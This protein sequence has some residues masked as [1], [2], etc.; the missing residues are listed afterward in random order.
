MQ[1][2]GKTITTIALVVSNPAEP[3][4]RWQRPSGAAASGGALPAAGT[5]IVAPTSLLTQWEAEFHAKARRRSISRLRQP[6]PPPLAS[7]MT[8]TNI[9]FTSP[10]SRFFLASSSR[11]AL[12]LLLS[13]PGRPSPCTCPRAV[14][15][16][17]TCSRAAA[18]ACCTRLAGGAGPPAEKCKCASIPWPAEGARSVARDARGLLRCHH[19]VH[20]PRARMR[21]AA[22][23]GRRRWRR[24]R[25]A[26]AGRCGWRRRESRWSS[27]SQRCALVCHL[28]LRL[29]REGSGEPRSGR[30]VRA[31]LHAHWARA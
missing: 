6:L 30:H 26:R 25:A 23:A 24:P 3:T 15:L 5:L 27:A 8:K 29:L 4:R 21:R 10:R 11:T 18:T 2:L 9:T 17:A 16:P 14:P 12:L 31:C 7:A 22:R 19:L 20:A 28:L 13:L 1:G